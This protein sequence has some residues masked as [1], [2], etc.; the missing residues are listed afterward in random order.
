[1][2]FGA[3][4]VGIFMEACGR[5]RLIQLSFVPLVIGWAIIGAARS[6]FMLCIGRVITDFAIG[7]RHRWLGVVGRLNICN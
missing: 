6:V 5:K 1:M 7:K 2:P 4:F 3:L